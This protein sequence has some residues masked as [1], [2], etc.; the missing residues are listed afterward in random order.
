M[1]LIVAGLASLAIW[2]MA[3]DRKAS[4]VERPPIVLAD[5]P[6]GD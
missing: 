1:F 3:R 4:T 5:E 2:Q 6:P